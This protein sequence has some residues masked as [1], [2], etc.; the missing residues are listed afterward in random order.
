ML[1]VL[2]PDPVPASAAPQA[3]A[4]A[5]LDSVFDMLLA[6]GP[7]MVPLAL[8]SLLAATYGI[9]RAFGLR[10]KALGIDGF[11]HELVAAV[12]AGGVARGVELC[13][14][15]ATPAA[16]VVK[17]ALVRWG[18]PFVEREKA[19]E[20]AGLREVR[21]LG[22]NLKPLMYVAMLA[23]LLGFLGTVYGMIVAFTTVAL[24]Q[25]LGR[26][27]MLAAG[28]SQAL[29]TTAAGL[30]I[31]VPAQVAYYWLRARVERFARRVEELYA[32]VVEA[33]LAPAP[34][35]TA[36]SFEAAS[37]EAASATVSTQGG[38]DVPA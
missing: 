28:I 4:A 10:S 33:L 5:P 7:V 6:G 14:Q 17:S 13:G 2:V 3:L 23:P 12:R 22:A 38:G 8:C 16:R 1:S 34:E 25:G 27:E 20:D 32:N 21:A 19:V 36:A 18:A 15:R 37:F 31:A 11:E 24:Q 26:P 30:T 29:I 9:E 35:P